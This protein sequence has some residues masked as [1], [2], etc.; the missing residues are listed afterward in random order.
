MNYFDM[1]KNRLVAWAESDHTRL[2]KLYDTFGTI[3]VA[4][5]CDTLS[6]RQNVITVLANV[7]GASEEEIKE[8][9][10]IE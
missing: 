5:V 2:N 8:I 4:E 9:N 6:Y 1:A 7:M 10:R 3:N